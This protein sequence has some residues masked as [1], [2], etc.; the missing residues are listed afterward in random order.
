MQS[1]T[2]FVLRK[3]DDPIT[4]N[5]AVGVSVEVR[6]VSDNALATLYLTNNVAGATLPNPMTSDENGKYSFFA[7][8][9]KY[10]ISIGGGSSTLEV[11]FN[12][13]L[14]KQTSTSD[15]T[16][17]SLMIVGAFGIGSSD[18]PTTSDLNTVST[19]RLNEIVN[20][21][22]NRPSEVASGTAF[23]MSLNADNAIQL[24]LGRSTSSS[25]L[26]SKSAGV[27]SADKYFMFRGDFGIGSTTLGAVTLDT[28]FT[29]GMFRYVAGDSA[30]PEAGGTGGPYQAL[31]ASP[32]GVIQKI[33]KNGT[34]KEWT[35]FYNGTV[36]SAPVESYNTGNLNY[37]QNN[38]G[39]TATSGGLGGL[40]AGASLVPATTGTW[41]NISGNDILN[42]GW[43]IWARVA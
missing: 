2:G 27:W 33:Y 10:R 38:S 4:G 9:G 6:Q 43:G 19:T 37:F 41:R 20:A 36:W 8:D 22:P 35:R 31:A 14:V 5:V 25:A 32:T 24:C 39:A 28:G 13:D 26:R 12:E 3:I 29:S 23:T 42:L 34:T 17:G 11:T 40:V 18:L 15:T 16:T 21:T 30:N 1:Y 7:V